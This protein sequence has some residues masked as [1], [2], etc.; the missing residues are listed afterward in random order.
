AFDACAAVLADEPGLDLRG[1]VF[2]D[3]AEAPLPPSIMQPATIPNAHVLA[4]WWMAQGLQ[5][6]AMVGHNV[7]ESDDAALAEGVE[8]PDAPRLVE[9]RGRLMQAQ[10]T[11][12][13]LSVR[14]PLDAL[15]P[16]LPATLSLAA[17]NAPGAC[18]VAGPHEEVAGFQQRLEGEGVACRLL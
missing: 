12:A 3:D 16:R 14:M 15:Q 1:L 7:G 9:R 2:G 8:P 13:M 5:P 17:E 18:V 4:R 11:G 10:P 6:V